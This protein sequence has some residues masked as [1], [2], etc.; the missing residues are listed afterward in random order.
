VGLPFTADQVFVAFADYNRAFIVAVLALWVAS[1]TIVA[2][3]SR[4]PSRRSILLIRRRTPGLLDRS[5][6]GC[7][8]PAAR[9]TLATSGM[10]CW[11]AG[12]DA[13]RVAL[14]GRNADPNSPIRVRYRARRRRTPAHH[15]R[16]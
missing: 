5:S 9:A 6:N 14:Q 8:I 11:R 1:I 2:H 4:D 12:L 15:L 10:S 13:F 16:D 3:V 7:K